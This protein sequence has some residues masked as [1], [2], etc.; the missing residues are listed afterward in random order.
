MTI[1]VLKPG[2][3]SSFQDEGRFG[4]QP[5][6]VSVVGAMDQ[7]AHRLA[8]TLVGNV[9]DVASLEITLTGPTL[10]FTKPCCIALCGADLSP[11]LNGK[12]I[13]MNRPL[14]LR[15]KDELH[16]GARQHGT[17]AYLAVHG[18]FDIPNILDSQSTYLRSH[19]GGWHGRALKRDDEIPLRRP[20]REVGQNGTLATLAKALWDIRLYLPSVIADSTRARIRII[21]SQ[22]WDEF[23]PASREALLSQTFRISPDS[24]RMGYRLQGPDILM[25]KPRQMISEATTFG[26]IQVP[27]G[28]QPIV[29]M[30]DRQTTGGY[31]KIAYVATVDLP[32]LAQMGPGDK[33]QFELITLETAQALDT[34]RTR[35]FIDLAQALHPVRTLLLHH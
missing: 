7:R 10:Q 26:T 15:A 1:R 21:K 27:A 24:E 33:V 25:T 5:L 35:A 11:Q 13:A 4:H 32:L 28:G 3:L 2:M 30:A 20:L 31:P 6:G 9:E 16:F 18:G 34:A 23:T 19:F 8:N 22:Q 29:L 14:V 12:P 17:R